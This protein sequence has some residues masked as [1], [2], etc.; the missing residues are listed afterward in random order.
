MFVK[1]TGS[2]GHK[3]LQIVKSIR[4]NGKPTHQVVA[5]LGRVDVLIASG[6]EN[7]VASLQK[8]VGQQDPIQP[9]KAQGLTKDISTMTEQARVNYGWIAY[10]YLWHQYGLSELLQRLSSSCQISYDYVRIVH[11]LVTNHLLTPSSK[12]DFAL[13]LDRYAQLLDGIPLHHIY[14]TLDLLSDHKVAIEQAVFDRNRTLFNMEVDVVFYDVTTFHFE[15]QRADDFR[16]FGFSKAGKVGEVQVVL[17]LLIDR[18]GR[19]IGFEL[20]PGNTFDGKTLVPVLSRLQ[21]DFKIGQVVIVADKGLNSKL[22]LKE[23]KD[24]GFDYIVS[25]RLK[26]MSQKMQTEVLSDTGYQEKPLKDV[27][28]HTTDDQEENDS[29]DSVKDES[30]KTEKPVFKYKLL[31]YTNVV[32]YRNEESGKWRKIKLAEKLI[33][34]WSSKRADKDKRDRQRQVDKAVELIEGNKKSALNPRGYKGLVKKE[35]VDDEDAKLVLNEAKI[36][37]AASFDGFAALQCSRPDCDGLEVIRQYRRL[38]RIEESFRV[39]KSTM[40]TRPI[41]L[42]TRKHIEGHFVMCFLAFLLERE[43]EY[44]LTKRKIEYSPER[45]KAAL[46]SMQFS[47]LD[48]ENET[49][50]LKGKHESLASQIFALLRIKQPQNLMEKKKALDYLGQ[51]KIV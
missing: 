44:R 10:R 25:C 23:I 42:Q 15:S 9:K 32:C 36:E 34:T 41:Y 20:F 43:L 2:K 27:F 1:T 8:I 22:N 48:I 16:D 38:L 26:S 47:I 21:K 4:K 33:C 5:N 30:E 17:G 13:H 14:R 18:D 46:K 39:M 6:L 3:Y 11:G 29:T 7:I 50:Y 31:D 51:N 40:K 45:I 24:A 35:G 28:G 49:Y 12:R 37:R 19:P